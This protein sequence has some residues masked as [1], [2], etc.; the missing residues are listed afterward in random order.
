M[1]RKLLIISFALAALF[2]V[3]TISRAEAAIEIIDNEYQ[4]IMIS[5]NA[6]KLH[7]TGANGQTLYIYNVTGV[8][9]MSIKVDSADRYYDLNLSRG[10]YIVK[11]GNTVRKISIKQ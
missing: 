2:V 8:C 6:S 5:V 7:V 3:P 9:V 11:V 10:C 1:K 4:E